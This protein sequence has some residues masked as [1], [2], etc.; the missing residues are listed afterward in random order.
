MSYFTSLRLFGWLFTHK[1]FNKISES[2][3][4]TL[5]KAR[6]PIS[7]DVYLCSAI[8]QSLL[9]AL[10]FIP[11]VIII[12][13]LDF[14]I[15]IKALF[16]GPTSI[17]LIFIPFLPLIAFTGT[18]LYFYLK[19]RYV[20]IARRHD[21]DQNIHHASAFLY[22][23]TKSGLQPL[24]ALERLSQQKSIYGLVAEEFGMAVRRVKYFGENLTNSLR[25]VANTTSSKHLREYIFSFILATQQSI[26]VGTYFKMKFSEFFE[27]EKRERETLIGT[28]N[29]V[30]EVAVVIVALSPTLVLAT[31]LS[32]GVLN[33]EMITLF[34]MYMLLILPLS[35][36]LVLFYIKTI[37]PS[38]KLILITKT[39]MQIPYIENVQLDTSIQV[40][41]KDLDK[42]DK[43]L[44]FKT[45]LRKPIQLLFI[46]PWFY[47]L[48]ATI[49]LTAIIAYFYI[50]GTNIPQLF[51]YALIGSSLIII[52]PHEVKS[53]YVVAVE[54][55]IPDFLR[56]L[57]E[58]V[59]REGSV[60]RA[61]NLVLKSR[62]GLLQREMK[63]ISSTKL[64][65][66]L[67]RA[68]LMIEYRTA[69]I[70]LKRVL[71]LL[72]VASESTKNMKDIL[73]MAADDAETYTK[74]RRERSLSLI[75]FL[76][77]TYVCFGVYIYTYWIL[78]TQFLPTLSSF[79][80][81]TAGAM[82]ASV[83]FQG[84]YIGLF[85]AIILGLTIGAMLEGSIRSGLK[86][87]LIMMIITIILL[88]WAP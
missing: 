20:T 74:L 56:G 42:S 1:P 80:G 84:Y 57:S 75:G 12:E 72:V 5:T 86:H 66:P 73:I 3:E 48:L 54:R 38:H 59:E 8:A 55:R 25:Y 37:L 14:L 40:T 60:I 82:F 27:T 79:P 65:V 30:G 41:E 46:Y 34:N 70:V 10:L 11:F 4:G 77:S 33:P 6:L 85:L 61:I 15:P 23:M 50:S 17:L 53:R 58:T 31:S 39:V 22:A 2:M 87:S 13:Y 76:I 62:L 69:S 64:G 26:S 19:P 51:V 28:M 44:R 88:G 63:R 7:G 67:K 32:L 78:K 71:S 35:S 16:Q 45:A 29:L 83:T 81:F 24:E 68:I 47:F 52:I 43:K 9:S 49:A 21:I 36:I 18:L